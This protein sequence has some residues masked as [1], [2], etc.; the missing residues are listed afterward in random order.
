[1][2]KSSNRQLGKRN[3]SGYDKQLLNSLNNK[4]SKQLAEEG[5]GKVLTQSQITIH[6]TSRQRDIAGLTAIGLF[7]LLAVSVYFNFR[8]Y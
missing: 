4:K 2:K 6:K 3:F 8:W 7:I 1:M 5:Y